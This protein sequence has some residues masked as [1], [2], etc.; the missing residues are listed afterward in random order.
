MEDIANAGYSLQAKVSDVF[1]ADFVWPSAW[2]EKYPSLAAFQKP[3]LDDMSDRLVWKSSDADRNAYV[4]YI[5]ES[6]RPRAQVVSWFDVVWFNQCIPK[7][8]FVMW[9]LMGERLKTQDRLKPWELRDNP[10]LICFE[11][12]TCRVAIMSAASRKSVVW[13]VS[14]LCFA[15]SV[16]HIWQERNARLFKRGKKTEEQLFE[17]IRSNV[18][19]KLMA[20]LFKAT[21]KVDQMKEDWWLC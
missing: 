15:A 8:A 20:T 1:G 2:I 5:W 17:S 4:S 16:Y 19:L 21:K 12:K 18:R 3:V 14:K 11:W 10:T 13:I 6:I 7:H 9:L